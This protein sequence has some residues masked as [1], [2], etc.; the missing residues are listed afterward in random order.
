MEEKQA[1][2]QNQKSHYIHNERRSVL[3]QVVTAPVIFYY[4]V[5]TNIVFINIQN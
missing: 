1:S 2:D 4:Y 3:Y 5:Y